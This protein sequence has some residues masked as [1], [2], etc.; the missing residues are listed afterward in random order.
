MKAQVSWQ[1]WYDWELPYIIIYARLDADI[2]QA[3]LARRMGTKQPS[4]ARAENGKVQISHDF[5]KRAVAACGLELLPPKLIFH[6]GKEA[7]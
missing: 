5:L 3:E 2:T 6:E 1:Q 4:I 7:E